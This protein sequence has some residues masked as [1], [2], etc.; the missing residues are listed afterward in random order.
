M[1]LTP[2]AM[3][4]AVGNSAGSGLRK[5][6]ESSGAGAPDKKQGRK[7]AKQP[8]GGGSEVAMSEDEQE[9]AEEALS[10]SNLKDLLVFTAQLALSAKNTAEIAKAV[11]VD[12]LAMKRTAPLVEAV[13]AVNKSYN[14]E[15]QALPK[16]KK[17]DMPPPHIGRF[18]AMVENV[19]ATSPAADTSE[20]AAALLKTI[21]AFHA[22][23]LTFTTMEE[24][25][26]YVGQSIRVCRAGPAFKSDMAKVEVAARF[27]PGLDP[28][29]QCLSVPCWEAMQQLL[30][31]HQGAQAKMGVAPKSN[32]ER[33]VQAILVKMGKF[34]VHANGGW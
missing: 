15:A 16:E 12:H 11:G 34:K 5:R 19:I 8:T 27:Q 9:N 3:S 33:K 14:E 23:V 25:Q 26:S 21:L 1:L 4:S 32:M 22:K 24:Q 20:E 7:G 30:R 10:S 13:K 6:V 18:M 2:A 28:D 31:R 17:G 29:R